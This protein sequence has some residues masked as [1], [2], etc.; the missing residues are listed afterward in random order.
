LLCLYILQVTKAKQIVLECVLQLESCFQKPD[1]YTAE[2]GKGQAGI[3]TS[4][5]VSLQDSV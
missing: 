2:P 1:Q 3:F 5:L 4:E